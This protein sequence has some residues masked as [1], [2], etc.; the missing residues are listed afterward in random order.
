MLE[1]WHDILK[2]DPAITELLMY[3]GLKYEYQQVAGWLGG[4]V[5]GWLGSWVAGWLGG[6]VVGWPS[7]WKGLL[8]HL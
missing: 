6:W 1:S 8:Y 5:A 7:W 2:F 4:W 3:E